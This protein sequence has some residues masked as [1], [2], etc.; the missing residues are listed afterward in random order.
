LANSTTLNAD[1]AGAPR[2]GRS[3]TVRAAIRPWLMPKTIAGGLIVLILITVGLSAPLIAPYDPNAQNL[4]RALRP[5]D[6]LFGSNM[7]GTDAV[8]R[9]I[10]SRL[11][12]GAR[13]SLV[14]AVL[15]VIISGLVGVVL[16]AISGYFAGV[17]DFLIQKLVEVIWAFPPL[18]LAIA[19][20]AFLGQGLENLILALVSQRWIAYCRVSRGQALSLRAREFVDA[21]R[22]L[23]ANHTRI[24]TRHIMPNLFPSAVVIG[25]FSMA[26][27][28]IAEA[29][30]SFLGLG[31]PP[32][33]PTWGS[34]LSDGR[35]Y[36]STS[37][38]LA[39]FP[40]LCIFFTVLGINLLGDGL[41]DILDPRLKR[42][43]SGIG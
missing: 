36:I 42:S 19:I 13:V 32:E 38:W 35:T 2:S 1:V 15:V 34:M 11:F 6:W 12:Y 3:R 40:G 18:L 43:G 14:I 29:A 33:I 27:A 5:P 30:L 21:A 8:G 26:S 7:L 9:D 10:L 24:I 16:G 37:W 25:T 39:L 41:R 23:G 31:V 22:L 4:A 20:M 28:I 17:T